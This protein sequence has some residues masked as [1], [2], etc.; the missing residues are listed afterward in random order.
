MSVRDGE[1]RDRRDS[2]RRT[3]AS[4][5]Q[6]CRPRRVH[7]GRQST[8]SCRTG[9]RWGWDLGNSNFG[10]VKDL[11]T[12]IGEFQT[13]DAG[14]YAFRYPVNTNGAPSLEK[15]FQFNVFQFCAVLDDLFPTLQGAAIGAHEDYENTLQALGEDQEY[16]RQYAD[17]KDADH[18]YEYEYDYYKPDY[19]PQGE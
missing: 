10:S 17:Q 15:D 18:G 7:R 11:R 6:P 13:I 3:N 2:H 4:G 19:E 5:P 16:G 12:V 1:V 9:L 14:S 8:S